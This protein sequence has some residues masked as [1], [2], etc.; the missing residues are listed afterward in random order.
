M[1]IFLYMKT[2]FKD[3]EKWLFFFRCPNPKR[4]TKKQ[5]N[6]VKSKNSNKSPEPDPKEIEA[7]KSDKKFKIT[8]RI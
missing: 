8:I 7:C 6:M 4:H 1:M 3:W 2:I 5:G